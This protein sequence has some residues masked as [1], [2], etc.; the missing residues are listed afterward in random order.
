MVGPREPR[1]K[2]KKDSPAE[3]AST[4]Q[5]AVTDEEWEAFFRR[6][7]ALRPHVADM[8]VPPAALLPLATGTDPEAAAPVPLALLALTAVSEPHETA[9]EMVHLRTLEEVKAFLG[10]DEAE[11]AAA[12]PEAQP[13][14]ELPTTSPLSLDAE[15]A[16]ASQ[17]RPLAPLQPEAAA[18]TAL[19]PQAASR[20][21][22]SLPVVPAALPSDGPAFHW[23][24]HD[25]LV[26]LGIVLD[27]WVR[28]VS[29]ESRAAAVREAVLEMT[30]RNSDLIRRLEALLPPR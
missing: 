9:P 23:Q 8:P 29:L 27:W 21:P 20:P 3:P 13:A 24:D 14:S 17:E 4:Q 16:S 15:P 30:A 26:L 7:L 2:G 5:S 19:E 18:G 1:K 12:A 22:G 11:P 28:G 10:R 6:S 25:D